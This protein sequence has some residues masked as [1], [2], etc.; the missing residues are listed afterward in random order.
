MQLFKMDLPLRE[1]SSRVSY[2]D[3][4]EQK[5]SLSTQNDLSVVMQHLCIIFLGF[6]K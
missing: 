5:A 6:L 4:A 3:C 1:Q 2:L